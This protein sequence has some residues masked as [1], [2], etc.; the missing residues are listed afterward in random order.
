MKI[1][2]NDD[3]KPTKV[4]N[5]LTANSKKEL[6]ALDEI[7]NLVERKFCIELNMFCDGGRR[8]NVKLYGDCAPSQEFP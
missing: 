4:P 7:I 3:I 8:Y 5:D 2:I 1:P 6:G